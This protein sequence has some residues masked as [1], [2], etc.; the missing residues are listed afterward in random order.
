MQMKTDVWAFVLDSKNG[1]FENEE[2][3]VRVL[4]SGLHSMYTEVFAWSVNNHLALCV[5]GADVNQLLNLFFENMD[6]YNKIQL[7][8]GNKALDYLWNIANDLSWQDT[9]PVEKLAAFKE[10][11]LYAHIHGQLGSVLSPVVEDGLNAL[12]RNPW[13]AAAGYSWL[14][15]RKKMARSALEIT[16]VHPDTRDILL[17]HNLN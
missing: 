1:V 10:S 13:V 12:V 16:G 3:S 17:R 6:Y 9:N 15:P 5:T 4:L 8:R 14:Q 11:Y 7:L 2:N